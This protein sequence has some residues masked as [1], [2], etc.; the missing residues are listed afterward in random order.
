MTYFIGIVESPL[1]LDTEKRNDRYSSIFQAQHV[2]GTAWDL[3]CCLLWIKNCTTFLMLL[4]GNLYLDN[5]SV[6]ESRNATHEKRYL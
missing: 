1:V 5:L 3:T 2:Y 6:A 4:K